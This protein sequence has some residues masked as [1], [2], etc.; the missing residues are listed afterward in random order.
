MYI[1]FLVVRNIRTCPTPSFLAHSK[2]P[3]RRNQE[4]VA[5]LPQYEKHNVFPVIPLLLQQVNVLWSLPP[6]Q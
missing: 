4:E 5:Q 2:G 1:A 3:Y 6:G